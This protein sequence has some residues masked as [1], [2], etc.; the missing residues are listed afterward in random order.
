MLSRLKKRESEVFC[1][2]I[3]MLWKECWDQEKCTSCWNT[4]SPSHSFGTFY[5]MIMW[6]GIT[7]HGNKQLK[8]FQKEAVVVVGGQLVCLLSTSSIGHNKHRALRSGEF[9]KKPSKLLE[10][11][12]SILVHKVDQPF[13]LFFLGGWGCLPISQKPLLGFSNP[14]PKIQYYYCVWFYLLLGGNWNMTESRK[15]SRLCILWDQI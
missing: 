4:A 7:P 6:Q 12:R 9:L 14:S 5:F 3:K 2:K 13:Y 11:F 15:M 8:I 10:P 1:V